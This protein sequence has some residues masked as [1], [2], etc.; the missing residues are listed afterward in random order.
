MPRHSSRYVPSAD[1]TSV[2][3]Q[4]DFPDHRPSID[5]SL[6]ITSCMVTAVSQHGVA[7][8][9]ERCHDKALVAQACRSPSCAQVYQPT[10]NEVRSRTLP[11]TTGY[12]TQRCRLEGGTCTVCVYSAPPVSVHGG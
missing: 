4:I 2:V 10:A 11:S 8:A 3:I 1:S 5:P 7:V 6:Y 12:E 9:W